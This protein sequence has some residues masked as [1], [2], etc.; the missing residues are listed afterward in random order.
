MP[1]TRVLNR[2]FSGG[3]IA[4][5][6]YGR[7]DDVKFQ[8]GAATVRNFI[9]LPQGPLANR[10]GFELVREVKNSA[11]AVRLI[12]FTFNTT[13]TM[14]IELGNQYARFHTQGATL[15]PGSP[16]A[17][18]GAT[19]YAIGDLVRNGGVNYYCIAATTGNAPPNA[20]YWYAMPAGI[21][22]IPTPYAA[23]DLF[24]IHYVQSADVL[25][26]VHPTYAPRELRRYGAT[27]WVLS[28]ISFG[29][30]LAAPT[31]LTLTKTGASTTTAPY[32]YVVTALS[33]DEINESVPSTS[34][35]VNA[36]LN[37]FGEYITIS[38][39]AVTGASRYNIYKLQGGIYGFIGSTT[40]LSIIDNNIDP[41]L[42]IIPPTYETVFASA[43]NYPGAVS[44]YEQRRI[45]AG[46][47]NDPQRLWM[48]KSGTESD[49]SYGIPLT[50]ADRISFRVAAREANTI[51]H[52][53]PL[54][55]L[56]LLT[57]A[58]EWRVT[59]VN[60]DALTPTSISV[61]PQSYVGASN[62]QPVIINNSLVYCASRGG[63]VR[64]LGYSWQS[65]GFITGD[66]SIRASHLFDDYNL[67]DM[68]YAKAPHPVVWFVSDN[69]KLLGLTYIP[70]QQLGSWH[71]HDTDGS[72]ESCACVSEGTEDRLYAV[73]RRTIN[74][75]TKRF[76]ERMAVRDMDTLEECVHMDCALTYD[77]TNT[78]ATTI[79]VTQ[80]SGTGWNASSLF[81][82]TAS[83]AIFAYPATTDI[84]DCIVLTD[85]SGN[86]YRLRIGSTSSTT[87]ATAIV[88]NQLPVS[89]RG[90]ATATWAWARDS[91]SGLSHLEGKTVTILADGCPMAQ[92]TVSS[93]VISLDRPSTLVHV[94]L[95]YNSDLKTLPVTLQID[96]FGQGR[97]K[98]VNKAWV[99]VERSTGLFV[100][101]DEDN[102]VEAKQ[103]TTEPPGSPP[104]LKS[105]EILV[106][107]TP[108]WGSTG[109]V[110][111]RQS[112]PLPMSIISMTAEVAIGG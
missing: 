18:S 77:G 86:K 63:H 58:A 24:N 20:T 104:D 61:R 66:L 9:V 102:L 96:A 29:A 67:V 30:V 70:E 57:S 37:A 14:I 78:G 49:M 107:M 112:D 54:T 31:G 99:R 110:F 26:L 27:K 64:E 62:V 8:T 55:Q 65:N 36:N 3:E 43:G 108:S 97:Y 80:T 69:G 71:Q 79:T 83:T 11:T 91:V 23:A 7:V 87:V 45:F 101:P 46:T 98:N 74:G 2:S 84:G 95:P 90:V 111:V 16:A 76:V 82:L 52:I 34:A 13:Q 93:G 42:S 88:D 25:T 73:I 32:R 4:P 89:L 106:V 56:I 59:S 60:S 33:S 100:G 50:D 10:P 44:Y 40:A 81:T 6:M 105:D 1:N 72:F 68:C 41:D 5:E 22:E 19:A 51:R 109:E 94:G 35:V 47:N 53:V 103:R 92:R 12:P 48:T 38:W 15:G 21:Y 75:A 17:Y 28:G 85:A 39:S